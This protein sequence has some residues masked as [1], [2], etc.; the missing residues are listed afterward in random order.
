MGFSGRL[1]LSVGHQ[2]AKKKLCVYYQLHIFFCE[3]FHAKSYPWQVYFNLNHATTKRIQAVFHGVPKNLKKKLCKAIA[4]GGWLE[5]KLT[6][7]AYFASSYSRDIG[8]GSAVDRP[9]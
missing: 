6:K 8:E 9:I 2:E 5:N 1:K 3:L 7:I 4:M